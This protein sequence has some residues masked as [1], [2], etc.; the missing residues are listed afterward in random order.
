S[1]DQRHNYFG[2]ISPKDFDT[3]QREGLQ[4]RWPGTGNWLLNHE[5]YKEWFHGQQPR[6]LW[7]H[8]RPG[9]GKS[10]LSSIVMDHIQKD[11]ATSN[12]GVGKAFVSFRYDDMETQKP[13]K[14]IAAVLKQLS[15]QLKS[16]PVDLADFLSA[17]FETHR[18]PS[19][20]ATTEMISKLNSLFSK[21]FIVM[22]ALDEC[23]ERP[24]AEIF[25]FISRSEAKFFITSR[26]ESSI[27][28]TF[29]FEKI[30]NLEIK[31]ADTRNDI[32]EYIR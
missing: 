18:F 24:R 22:D 4:K 8:G 30:T 3:I 12:A 17:H 32:E 1:E 19:P 20:E 9:S 14:I 26:P 15:S 21:T 11:R 13:A 2:W 6:V 28:E 29:N 7:C 16:F 31:T 5:K 25:Q 27:R 23:E 10:V